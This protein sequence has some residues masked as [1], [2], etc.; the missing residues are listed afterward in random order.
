MYRY[1]LGAL[2]VNRLRSAKMAAMIKFKPGH[3]RRG[4]G[5]VQFGSPMAEYPVSEEWH[6][7]YVD[8]ILLIE[9]L[10]NDRTV[11]QCISMK[12]PFFFQFISPA[13]VKC[14]LT[15]CFIF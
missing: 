4:Q 11:F 9:K 5:M 3:K 2:T 13:D 1:S 6:E 14:Q 15:S 7:S 12:S 10:G 8:D